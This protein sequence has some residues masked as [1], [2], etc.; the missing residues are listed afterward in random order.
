M[1]G[2]VLMANF[3]VLVAILV[4]GAAPASGANQQVTLGHDVFVP[5]RVAVAPGESV[6]WTNPDP[7]EEHNVHFEDHSFIAPSPPAA[8]P[9]TRVRTFATEPPGAYRYYCE[10]HGGPGGIGMSGIVYVN[11]S[12][13]LPPVALFTATP[14][15]A[16]V[17]QTVTFSGS[18]STA[19]TGGAIVNYEWDL[20]GNGSFETDT[21]ATSS[22]S[23]SY[24][25]PTPNPLSI[26]LR[27]TDAAG[28]TAEA[29]EALRVTAAPTASFTVSPNPAQT[30]QS[31]TFNASASTDSDGTIASYQWDL[32]GD[33]SYET[34]T[35]TTPTASRSYTTAGSREVRLRVIDNAGI[36]A[37][38]TRS[39]QVNLPAQP[40]RPVT[41]PVQPLL[42]AA[43]S[44][45][46]ANPTCSS[47]AGATR[48]AC[49][50]R[51]CTSLRGTRRAACIQKSCRYVRGAARARCLLKSCRYVKRRAR[52]ACR[53]K[54]CR[55]LK[56]A[57]KRACVKKYGRR[58]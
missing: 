29:T 13:T 37:E 22:A 6:T 24:T 7:G 8:G 46:A 49:M 12:G 5:S 50:Q 40:R 35:A 38:A 3:G 58:R 2:R 55:A 14:S 19:G 4:T 48:T 42:P 54:S 18:A 45:P 20:D 10:I 39:V 47:L 51:Q 41:A 32:D 9:W 57:K 27:V 43:P 33:G 11:S 1:Q 28:N 44:T 31:V 56:G 53:L 30:G 17:G 21:D 25:S 23:R 15:V 36:A 26:K 16:V 34:D 52:S